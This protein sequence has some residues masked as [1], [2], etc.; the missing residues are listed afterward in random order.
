MGDI[1]GSKVMETVYEMRKAVLS[2]EK[3]YRHVGKLFFNFLH[4]IFLCRAYFYI[5]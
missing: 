5:T 2:K 4:S 1:R 3:N